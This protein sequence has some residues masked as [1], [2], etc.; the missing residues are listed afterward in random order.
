MRWPALFACVLFGCRS[1][2]TGPTTR[3]LAL[4]GDIQVEAGATV[5]THAADGTLIDRQI[6]DGTGHV[7]L[8]TQPGALVTV[9]YA[10]P[11]TIEV[12][13]T[14]ALETGELA[15]HGPVPA[16]API[17]AGALA[18]TAP[19][20]T[21]DAFEIDLGCTT[22]AVDA[23][24]AT[25][26]VAAAC[27]GSDPQIDVLIRATLQSPNDSLAGY[28][29]ARVPV[30]DGVGMLDI[31]AWEVTPAAIPITQND[32]G[33]LVEV[34]EVADGFIYP[35]PAGVDHATAWT[36]LVAESS[37]VQAQVGFTTAGQT[38]TRIV[39]GVP[40]SIAFAAS[41]FMPALDTHVALRD[42]AKL[43]FAWTAPAVGD[44]LDFEASWMPAAKQIRWDAVLPPDADQIAFPVLDAALD[45][46]L[47]ALLAPPLGD[48]ALQTDLRAID[49]PDTADFASLQAGGLWLLDPSGATSSATSGATIVPPPVA[50]EVRQANVGGYD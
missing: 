22:V 30:V 4:A 48:I 8:L 26:D 10:R 33:A 11:E 28:F 31:P 35:A 24:P 47:A 19:A 2:D 49:G 29:A 46:D 6:T 16:K 38:T 17:I 43:V 50:G 27:L 41:D 15:I 18:L 7:E 32:L 44:V 45:P 42:R 21:A 13:T 37:R 39:P 40:D 25:V 20:I 12:I 36:G 14:P 23:F 5:L 9:I 3:V 34:D 1:G